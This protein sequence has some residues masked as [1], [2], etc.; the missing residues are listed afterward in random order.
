MQLKK[1]YRHC[2]LSVI[3]LIAYIHL[4]IKTIYWKYDMGSK[5][6]TQFKSIGADV[7]VN[8][9]ETL[10]EKLCIKNTVHVIAKINFDHAVRL[11]FNSVNRGTL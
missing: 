11:G 3:I 9:N 7:Y 6:L 8:N 10:N 5:Q 4:V 1:M 2:N